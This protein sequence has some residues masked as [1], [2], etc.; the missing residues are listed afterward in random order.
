[1]SVPPVNSTEKLSP[2]VARKNTASR[3]VMAEMTLNTNACFMNGMVRR[4]LKNSMA[5]LLPL[6]PRGVADR[7]VRDAPAVPVHQVDEA[8]RH[9]HRREHGG[10]DAQTMHDREAAH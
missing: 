1:M 3:N 10:A 6:F 8:A 2:R 4:I 5:R 7:Q 9:D